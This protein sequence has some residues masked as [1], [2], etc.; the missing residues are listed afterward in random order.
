MRKQTNANIIHVRTHTLQKG[1]GSIYLK[2]W[3]IGKKKTN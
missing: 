2:E 3:V 1:D